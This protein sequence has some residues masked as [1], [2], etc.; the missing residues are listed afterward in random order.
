MKHELIHSLIEKNTTKDRGGGETP[1]DS[2]THTTEVRPSGD[3]S[4]SRPSG[5]I[6]DNT[7]SRKNDSGGGEIRPFDT[8]EDRGGG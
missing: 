8:D 1:I 3:S 4:I 7:H 2:P 5:I 6:R